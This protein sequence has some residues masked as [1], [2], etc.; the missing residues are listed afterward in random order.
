MSKKQPEDEK[1]EQTEAPVEEPT[2]A[3]PEEEAEPVRSEAEILRQQLSELNDKHLRM[4]AEYDNFRRRSKTER[5]NIYADVRGD[6][7]KKFLPVFDNLLRAAEQETDP[8]AK[9]G[10]EAILNQFRSVLEGLGVKEIE[11]V[12]KKF[13]PAL[14]DAI[15][16][17]EDEKYGEGEIVLELTK[18][19]MLGDKVIRFS[20][21][22][23][24]N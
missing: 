12:G 6:T 13:D 21:V 17:I 5:E 16:H 18:G 11:A 10:A 15:L 23:V 4:L 7:V 22:Q 2:E 14:H 1:I 8:E 9:K 20:A 3:K 24:A 19:F